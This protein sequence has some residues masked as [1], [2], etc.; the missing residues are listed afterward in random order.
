[1]LR[2]NESNVN[3]AI[4][5]FRAETLCNRGEECTYK[6]LPMILIKYMV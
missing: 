4:Q 2:K 5:V 1:M 6:S 3:V